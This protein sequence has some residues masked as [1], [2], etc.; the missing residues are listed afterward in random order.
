MDLKKFFSELKRRN[1]YKV[2]ITYVIVAWLILQIGSVVFETIKAPAWVMQV[3]LFFVV[4]GFPIA[5]ILAW[6]FEMTPEGM[7]RTS[8][9]AA[10]ENHYSTGKKKSLSHIVYICILLLI[11]VGQFIYNKYWNQVS[12]N[13]ANTE[14]SIAVLPIRNDS[15]DKENEYFCNGMMEGILDHLEKIGDLKV[16]SRTSVEQ[17]R[18]QQIMNIKK[19][20]V[21]LEVVYIMEGSVQ[22]QGDKLRITAQ[23]IDVASGN[24]LWSQTYD[25]KY[26]DEIFKFQSAISKKIAKSMNAVIS[27]EE[28]EN[29][30]ATITMDIQAYDKLI[31]ANYEVL[32]YWKTLDDKLLEK[33]HLLLDQALEIEPE[34]FQALS[35]KGGIYA[36]ER[37]LDSAIIYL[38]KAMK[39]EP[40]NIGNYNLL[41]DYYTFQGDQ[42]NAIKQYTKAIEL[43]KDEESYW[44]YVALGR[45]YGIINEPI[46]AIKYINIAIK[47]FKDK[48][49]IDVLPT[50]HYTIACIYVGI[51]YYKKA[52]YY[53]RK[54]IES[55]KVGCWPEVGLMFSLSSQGKFQESIEYAQQICD[56]HDNCIIDCESLLCIAYFQNKQFDKALE[57]YLS[58]KEPRNSLKNKAVLIYYKQ[59]KILESNKILKEQLAYYSNYDNQDPLQ[60]G[61]H[62]RLA[63]LYAFQGDKEKALFHLQQYIDENHYFVYGNE[64]DYLPFNPFYEKLL[65]DKDFK[66]FIKSVQDRNRA[67]RL[68]VDEMEKNGEIE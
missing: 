12:I 23:L 10:K 46:K 49:F 22:K 41:G 43:M 16:K 39:I 25:G 3:L 36:T 40:N 31:K 56:N 8:S 62:N 17:Y 21:E 5:L 1:V 57:Y 2:A 59:G 58:I 44:P 28:Q 65:E 68:Q 11:I 27:P 47:D 13:T 63:E 54:A 6:A 9:T 24:H 4:I 34:Y 37:K 55:E 48:G 32:L 66:T 42:R 30:D 45:S 29:L 18:G 38:S 67:Y 60:L 14:K 35:L 53:F 7:I 15:S 33:A 51:S 20:G 50:T 26:T 19:I 64:L 61:K 52:D